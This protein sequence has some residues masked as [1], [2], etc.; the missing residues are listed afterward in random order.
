MDI[1]ERVKA[2]IQKK[3][4]VIPQESKEHDEYYCNDSVYSNLNILY[5][6]GVVRLEH[7]AAVTV[8]DEAGVSFDAWPTNSQK[9]ETRRK[10]VQHWASMGLRNYFGDD[11]YPYD[12]DEESS[13]DDY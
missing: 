2:C 9:K 11:F 5:V 8:E 6:T 1:E 4:F 7:S 10:G 13:S 12:S 3:R